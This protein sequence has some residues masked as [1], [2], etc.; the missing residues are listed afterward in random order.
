MAAAFLAT[1]LSSDDNAVVCFLHT[2]LDVFMNKED[3]DFVYAGA[4][5]PTSEVLKIKYCR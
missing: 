2:D 4:K 3:I 5:S 1:L